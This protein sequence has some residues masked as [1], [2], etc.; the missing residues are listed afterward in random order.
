VSRPVRPHDGH[1]S[2]GLVHGRVSMLAHCPGD[3]RG[4][5][6]DARLGTQA[7]RREALRSTERLLSG[8]VHWVLAPFQEGQGASRTVCCLE[9][10]RSWLSLGPR[11]SNL[12]RWT[13]DDRRDAMYTSRVPLVE[14]YQNLLPAAQMAGYKIVLTAVA[15]EADSPRFYEDV[16]RYWTSLHD[17][18]GPD[19]LFVFAGANA[20]KEL[21]DYGIPRRRDSVAVISDHIALARDDGKRRMHWQGSSRSPDDW[22]PMLTFRRGRPDLVPE[23]DLARDQTLE[24]QALRRFL[25][26]REVQLPCL[27]FTLLSPGPYDELP[28]VTVPFS[29]FEA[30]TVYQYLKGISEHLEGRFQVIDRIGESIVDLE[31]AGL[32]SDKPLRRIHDLRVSIRDAAR[33]LKTDEA[34]DAVAHLLRATG[35]EGRSVAMRPECFSYFQAV[36]NVQDHPDTRSWAP[37]LVPQLQRLIDLSF[38]EKALPYSFNEHD[39]WEGEDDRLLRA[40]RLRGEET[41]AWSQL[42]SALQELC[43]EKRDLAEH[44]QWDFF[45]AYSAVDESIAERAFSELSG[46]GRAFLDRRCLRPGDRWTDRIRT[47]QDHSRSTVFVVTK[48]TPQSWF[49]ESEYL[50]AIQLMRNGTHVVIPVLYGRD[51]KLPY[52]LEQVHAARL[53]EWED[54]DRLPELVRYVVEDKEGA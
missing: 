47:A 21:D 32:Q 44:E 25:G 17:A 3:P 53:E 26:L 41:E 49:A 38:E 33:G 20:A 15:R 14:F 46:V 29:R 51:A 24:I 40:S 45:I 31:R 4:S 16:R 1:G 6:L 7:Q 39:L 22:D 37:G 10:T 8:C 35:A 43:E 42:G 12:L 2:H 27:A 9:Y 48:E 28:L 54:L 52:G 18:T 11:W 30:S 23:E 50:H 5:A 19:I 36:R 34:R 13:P